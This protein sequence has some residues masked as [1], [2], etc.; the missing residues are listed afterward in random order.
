MLIKESKFREVYNDYYPLVFNAIYSKLGNREDTEELCH[1][2]FVVFY[3]NA[4]S[5]YNT[6]GWLKK[7]VRYHI[8]TY[9]RNMKPGDKSISIDIAEDDIDF[10]FDKDTD[11]IGIIIN[12]A[13]DNE[14]N[15]RND[16]DKILF[17][18]IAVYN[19]TY[20]QA[21]KQLGLTRRQAE[22]SYTQIT[23]KIVEYLKKKGI[24]KIEDLL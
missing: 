9:F 15:Y 16:K 2:I 14:E 6:S 20:A 13:I 22:Y 18:L 8:M 5:I 19:Y 21:G 24:S 12:E 17:Q 1:D 3:K 23:K 10:K 7:S 11:D 4:D